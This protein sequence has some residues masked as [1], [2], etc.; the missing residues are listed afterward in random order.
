MS[1]HIHALVKSNTDNLSG[2]LRDFKSFTSKKILE[3]IEAIV[4]TKPVLPPF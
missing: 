2:T 1:N 3:E 4:Q